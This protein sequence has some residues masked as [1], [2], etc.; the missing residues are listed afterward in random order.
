MMQS[1]NLKVFVSVGRTRDRAQDEFVA[2]IEERIRA[3]GLRPCTVGRNYFTDELALKAV[4][5]LMKECHGAVVI[6]FE[7]Y[8][9]SSGTEFRDHPHRQ[10]AFSDVRLPTVW[11]QTEAAMAYVHGLPTLLV[12]EE[13]LRKEGF[14]E[15]EYP[16]PVNWMNLTAAAL[17]SER[18]AGAFAGWMRK[19]REHASRKPPVPVVEQSVGRVSTE[20][21]TSGNGASLALGTASMV[22]IL[23]AT[24]G[25]LILASEFAE[26]HFYAIL[27]SLLPL[28][29]LGLA[30]VARVTGLIGGS[31][32]V[33]LFG[34]AR[35]APGEKADS[36]SA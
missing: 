25:L 15:H 22:A 12:A 7:R 10:Q 21:Q 3:Q 34:L 29:I 1:D 36:E 31:Q 23:G 16:W 19:V 17:G 18:F 11:N 13:G 30:F 8:H 9:Y 5:D 24:V 28:M 2:A 20:P 27:A 6:A 32:M 14:F 4:I 26:K 35:K 33:Q